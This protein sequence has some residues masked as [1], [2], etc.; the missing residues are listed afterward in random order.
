MA[1][2]RRKKH[3]NFIDGLIR[4]THMDRKINKFRGWRFKVERFWVQPSR[5]AERRPDK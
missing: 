3:K 2:K 1:A 4:M 5:C